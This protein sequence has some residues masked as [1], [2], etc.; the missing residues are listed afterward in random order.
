M[1]KMKMGGAMDGMETDGESKNTFAPSVKSTPNNVGVNGELPRKKGK[2]DITGGIEDE[3]I[4]GT[5]DYTGN[6]ANA[7][8][9]VGNSK[10]V[11]E[12][13]WRGFAPDQSP[14]ESMHNSMNTIGGKEYGKEH[15]GVKVNGSIEKDEGAEI[16]DELA[17]SMSGKLKQHLK[18]ATSG[19]NPTSLNTVGSKNIFNS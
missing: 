16:V 5:I 3:S 15:K 12:D 6:T 4:F 7:E 19:K 18:A 11:K 10:T 2:G 13:T 1:K 14:E 8:T 9:K 17:P